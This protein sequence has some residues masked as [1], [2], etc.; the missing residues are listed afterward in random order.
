MKIKPALLA[1]FLLG[2]CLLCACP[3]PAA[4]TVAISLCYD[5]DHDGVAGRVNEVIEVLRGERVVLPLLADPQGIYEE[6]GWQIVN[7]DGT[8]GRAYGYY[9]T[10]S[11]PLT[12]ICL[13]GLRS[14]DVTFIIEG[15]PFSTTSV[16]YGETLDDPY[17]YDLSS[18]TGV[19]EG[20]RE[21]LEGRTFLYWADAEG[22]PWN[23]ASDTVTDACELHAVFAEEAGA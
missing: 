19:L 23:M 18:L 9:E 10:A 22:N 3:A 11:E 15:Y 16:P 13:W 7:A 12:L 6:I 2:A 17:P 5:M 4:D 14:F 20:W 1:L 8:L 21:M